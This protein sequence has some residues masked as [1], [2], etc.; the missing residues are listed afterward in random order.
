M[1]L[2]DKVAVVTGGAK[3]IGRAICLAFAREGAALAVNYSK[4]QVEAEATVGD[5]EAM[6]GQAIAV[7]AD[8]G[9]DAEAHALIDAAVQQ[10]GRLDILVNN[11]A[12]TRYTP[13]HQLDLLTEE[14]IDRTLAVNLKGPICCARAAIPHMLKNGAG[15]I[16]NITSVAGMRGAG[17]SIVYCASKAG[18][19]VVTKS[20]ARAFAPHIRVNSIAPGFVDT[21]FVDWPPGTVENAKKRV[22]I[23]R[24]VEAEDIAA[25]ALFL[26]TDGSAL[27]AQEI[28]V[29][30]GIIAL[31]ARS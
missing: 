27:T 3:G 30:G 7:R 26:V 18:L 2:K 23:G 21:H 14:L 17:S 1:Q 9:Q 31:G 24:L 12:Y 5:I 8:V 15:F 4:S 22:H 20:L 11:A 25:V 6:G 19:S 28:V 10:F 29:D 16:V 13:H